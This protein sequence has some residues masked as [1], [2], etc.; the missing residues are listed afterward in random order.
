[1]SCP[2]Q[3]ENYAGLEIFP[4][5]RTPQTCSFPWGLAK[6]PVHLACLILLESIKIFFI[7]PHHK[8]ATHCLILRAPCHQSNL[9]AYKI[10]RAPEIIGRIFWSSSVSSSTFLIPHSSS[11]LE[12]QFTSQQGAA[13]NCW[14]HPYWNAL[15]IIL[16]GRGA[17]F[18]PATRSWFY[19]LM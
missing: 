11:S 7:V 14:V 2:Q 5:E 13:W 6:Y 10:G 4:T 12:K 15:V 9:A 18:L 19:M 3:K 17:R 1:M 8:A 16:S